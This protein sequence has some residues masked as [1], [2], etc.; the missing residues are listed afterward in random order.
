M[1][2]CTS[3]ISHPS[4]GPGADVVEMKAHVK[5]DVQGIGFR[6]ET[7]FRATRLALK[8]TVYNCPD[9]SVEILAQGP[10][11]NLEALIKELKTTFKSRHIEEIKVEFYPPK[12]QF[13]GFQIS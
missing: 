12:S 5:G 2:V 1:L 11:K 4:S 13:N 3:R 7:K 10:K 8:G 9:G 6:A